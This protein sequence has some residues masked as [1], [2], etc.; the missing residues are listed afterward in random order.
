ML[1]VSWIV[2][3]M[4]F[5]FQFVVSAPNPVQSSVANISHAPTKAAGAPLIATPKSIATKTKIP[6]YIKN[7]TVYTDVNGKWSVLDIP[8]E[9]VDFFR[10][11][12]AKRE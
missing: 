5:A 12:F 2:Y 11:I 8:G 3:V 1:L 10:Y 7:G 6:Y 4:A 9:I